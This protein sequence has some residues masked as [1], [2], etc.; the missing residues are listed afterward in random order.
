MTA[1]SDL[2]AGPDEILFGCERLPVLLD[3]K[4][5]FGDMADHGIL[6]RQN[7]GLRSRLHMTSRIETVLKPGMRHLAIVGT[8]HNTGRASPFCWAGF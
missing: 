8:R 4:L 7:H 6:H 1:L 3:L 5:P 2:V